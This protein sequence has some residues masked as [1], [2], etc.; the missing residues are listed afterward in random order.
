[1]NRALPLWIAAIAPATIAGHA[2]A[3]ALRGEAVTDPR[4]TWLQPTLEASL[5]VLAA[6]CALLLGGTLVRAGVLAHTSTER[7]FNALVPRLIFAQTALFTIVECAEGTHPAVTG[8][9]MQILTACVAALLLSVFARV[10]ARCEICALSISRYRER[11]FKAAGRYV[12]RR[13][14]SIAYELSLRVGN[15]RFQRPPPHLQFI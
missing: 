10:L 7:H 6:T 11:I 2:A 5:A 3:Y 9:L 4:H 12:R 14:V 15:A 1:M 8:Y 13:A